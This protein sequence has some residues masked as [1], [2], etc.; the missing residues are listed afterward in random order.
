[1]ANKGGF[2]SSAAAALGPMGGGCALLS[3]GAVINDH[4][5]GQMY[6]KDASIFS[7][8]VELKSVSSPILVVS[9]QKATLSS[10]LHN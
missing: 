5:A 9:T 7:T 4:L 8:Q 1:M 10:L 3:C 2:S 6:K